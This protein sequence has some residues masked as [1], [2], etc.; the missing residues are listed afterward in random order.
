MRCPS[1][2]MEHPPAWLSLVGPSFLF[3]GNLQ[4]SNGSVQERKTEVD[5]D[6]ENRERHEYEI[7]SWK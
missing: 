5:G 6:H 7:N 1:E 4:P 2:R 3:A